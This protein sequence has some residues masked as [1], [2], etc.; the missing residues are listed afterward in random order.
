M[1]DECNKSFV[2]EAT[3]PSRYRLGASGGDSAN[4]SSNKLGPAQ[5][6]ATSKAQE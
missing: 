5:M 1:T 3:E 6:D 2:M 4:V